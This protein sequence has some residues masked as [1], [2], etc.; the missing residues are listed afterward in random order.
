MSDMLS[1]AKIVKNI[2][3]DPRYQKSKLCYNPFP[4]IPVF[5]LYCPDTSSLCTTATTIFPV[6]AKKLE[7][8]LRRAVQSTKSTII[9][10]EGSQGIGK[11]HFLG[12]VATNCEFLGL[13]PIF[14]QIYTGGGFSDITDRAFQWLGLEGYT[15]LMLSFVKAIGLSELEIFQKNPYTIFHELIPMFQHAFNMQ[16]RKVLE[17]ILRPFLNLDIG[18]S[19]LFQTSHKYKNLILVTLI[20]LI[21]KTLSKKTLLVIDNLE[22]RWPYFTTLNKAHFLSNMKIFVNSTNGKVIMMLSDDGQISKYLIRELKDI[23]VELSIQRLKLPRLTIAKSIKLVSEYL[24]I[25]RIPQKKNY[26]LHPFTRESIKFI[27]NISN[28]NTRTFLVLCHDILEEYVKSDHS[29]ITVNGTRKS[30]N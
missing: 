6:K 16:D 21:W 26:N 13:F 9:F 14:C 7:N 8:I 22:N 25:A 27:Y 1:Y 18:Y 17:R 24:Q 2:G 19:A 5:S 12:E 3:V 29:K 28:G 4:A 11:S 10:I 20:H 23:N 15:Q 30:L